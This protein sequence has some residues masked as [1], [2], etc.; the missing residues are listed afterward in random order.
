MKYEQ[1]CILKGPAHRKNEYF[2]APAQTKLMQP[3][4]VRSTIQEQLAKKKHWSSGGHT[5]PVRVMNLTE[6]VFFFCKLLLNGA[7]H[8]TKIGCI[9]LVW[10][11]AKKYFS[12]QLC[13]LRRPFKFPIQDSCSS[14]IILPNLSCNNK[15]SAVSLIQISDFLCLLVNFRGFL[16]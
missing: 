12:F 13:A 16:V 2:L 4:S 6:P 8:Y 1:T 5:C 9:R 3:I 10:A 14:Q 11:G 15:K 7:S